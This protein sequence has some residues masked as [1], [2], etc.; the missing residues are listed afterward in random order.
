[1]RRTHHSVSLTMCVNFVVCGRA[2]CVC[3]LYLRVSPDARVFS[4]LRVSHDVRWCLRVIHD[5]LFSVV[6]R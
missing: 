2:V 5:V 1:M 6:C 4:C 3:V